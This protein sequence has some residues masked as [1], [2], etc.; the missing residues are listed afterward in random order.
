MQPLRLTLIPRMP[1]TC[2]IAAHDPWFIQLLRIYC[3]ECG[4]RVAQAYES[5]DVLPMTLQE[6]PAVIFLQADLPGRLQA[7]EVLPL[8]HANPMLCNVPVLLFSWNAM[9]NAGAGAPTDSSATHL[10]EPVTFQVFQDAL[11][12][13]GV[14]I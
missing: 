6:Q 9:P 3:E 12:Q 8:L 10:Q 11:R 13:A 4:F 2:L 1:E 7:S 5:Q 14:K